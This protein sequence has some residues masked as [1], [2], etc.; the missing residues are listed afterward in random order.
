MVIYPTKGGREMEDEG[1]VR[2]VFV[3]SEVAARVKLN[4]NYLLR[5]AKTLNL[6]ES[7]MRAAGSRNILFSES[8]VKKIEAAKSV[9]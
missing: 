8:A 6:G 7:E 3:T 9:K 2:R 5:L 4:A 1:D